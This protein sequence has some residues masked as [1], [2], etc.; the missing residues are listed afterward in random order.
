METVA[1]IDRRD[2]MCR[3]HLGFLNIKPVVERH[4]RIVFRKWS[5]EAREE[6]V[7][8]AVAAAFE[9][10]VALKERGRQPDRFP[11]QLACF[12]ALHVKDDRHVGGKKSAR[13]V[14]SRTTQAAHAF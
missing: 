4:A 7:A 2:S 9:S 8:E 12:A 5:K 11:F 13:D 3:Q 10:Y 6:A 1:S 14:S